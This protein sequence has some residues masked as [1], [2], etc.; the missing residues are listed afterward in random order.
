MK[1]EEGRVRIR[2]IKGESKGRDEVELKEGKLIGRMKAGGGRG[3][4]ERDEGTGGRKKKWTNE[5]GRCSNDGVVEAIRKREGKRES[6]GYEKGGNGGG[7]GS[8][9]RRKMGCKRRRKRDGRK[10][11]R[12]GFVRVIKEA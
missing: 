1:T 9:R 8:E 4:N 5:G 3:E 11:G 2:Q 12:K 6:V 10:D 7:G